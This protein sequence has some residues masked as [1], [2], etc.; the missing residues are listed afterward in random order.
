MA[1]LRRAL[2]GDRERLAHQLDSVRSVDIGLGPRS[3]LLIPRVVVDRPLSRHGHSS[4]FTGSVVDALR[5]ALRQARRPGE[6]HSSDDPLLFED[7]ADAATAVISAWLAGTARSERR[8][9]AQ[10]T[11][12]LDPPTW[13]RRRLLID[14]VLLPCVIERLAEKRLA[15]AWMLRLDQQ[16]VETALATM[17]SGQGL[18]LPSTAGSKATSREQPA[19]TMFAPGAL[20]NV[21]ECLETGLPL[22]QRLLVFIALMVRRRPSLLCTSIVRRA[23][24]HLAQ[25][26][27]LEPAKTDAAQLQDAD[28]AP[29]R[30][31]SRSGVRRPTGAAVALPD[32]R[33]LIESLPSPAAQTATA[34]H[35]IASREPASHTADQAVATRF[36][37]MLFVL[38]ALLALELY[39]DFSRPDRR[40]LGLSPFTLLA[41]LGSIWFGRNFRADPL[42]TALLA[43]AGE[44]ESAPDFMPPDWAVP[45]FWLDPWPRIGAIRIGRERP[46]PLLWHRA[47]FPLAELPVEHAGAASLA[48]R[49]L[50]FR[51]IERAV[52]PPRLPQAARDRWITCLALYLDARL[53]LAVGRRDGRTL[54]C[55]RPAHIEMAAEQVTARFALAEHPLAIRLAGLDRD[56]GWLPAAGRNLQFVFE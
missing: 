33:T 31:A 45:G 42:H 9:W 12:D 38:N 28:R 17:A 29:K 39:G 35:R 25:L 20:G 27:A 21:P 53:G 14:P 22:R 37:G 8:W 34:T 26:A 41:R 13:W 52:R 49:R 2:A 15:T 44:G 55:R 40:L 3:I 36:G 51:R 43:L 32:R 19:G 48:A 1:R 4:R 11:G 18:E 23:Y 30:R 47:G 46:R 5:T 54:L 7:K 10:M 50:G 56:P 6:P 16:D 24:Q